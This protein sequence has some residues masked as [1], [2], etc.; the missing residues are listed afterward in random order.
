MAGYAIGKL[1][2]NKLN[3]ESEHEEYEQE[4]YYHDYDQEDCYD[5][6]DEDEDIGFGLS[7]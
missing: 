2:Y 3:D 4:Q 1:S 5:D 7:M 6:Y